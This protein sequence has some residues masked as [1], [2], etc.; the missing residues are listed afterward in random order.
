MND[1]EKAFAQGRSDDDHSTCARTVVQIDSI[2]I[3]ENSGSL[4]KRHPVLDEIRLLLFIVPFEIAVDNGRHVF[5]MGY[6]P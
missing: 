1:A 2:G 5:S 3:G 4:R 6:S